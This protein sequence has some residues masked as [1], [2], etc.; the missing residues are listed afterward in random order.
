LF[1]FSV[2]GGAS[3]IVGAPKSD[4]APDAGQAFVFSGENLDSVI[5]LQDPNPEEGALFG[6]D[7]SGGA[8]VI[9]GAPFSDLAPDAGQAFVFSG[10]NFENVTTLNAPDSEE[11]ALFGYSVSGAGDV[12]GDGI[13]DVIVGAPF[14][15]VITNPEIIVDAGKVYIFLGP[16]FEIVITLIAPEPQEGAHFGLSVSEGVG[17]VIA[18]A[19]NTDIDAFTDAGQALFFLSGDLPPGFPAGPTTI[20]V[21]LDIKPQSCPNPINPTKKGILPVAIL[22]TA[23]F[24]V[25][26]INP[27][28]ILLENIP[29]LR[30]DFEDLSTPLDGECKDCTEEGP[31][32]F[33]D[34]TLKFD[35][36]EIITILG[37]VENGNELCLLLTGNLLDGTPIEGQDGIVIRSKGKGGPQS[38]EES[39]TIPT[40]FALHQN[41][42]NPFTSTTSIRYALPK[43]S[44]VS[45]KIY[46]ITGRAVRT[47]VDGNQKAQYYTIKWDGKDNMGEKVATGIYFTRF[48]AGN[49]ASTHKTVLLR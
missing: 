26:E 15:D 5:I 3:V 10:E 23:S 25:N 43:D 40:R 36:R 6:F 8:S 42:P 35:I 18:G 34:L 30:D 45:L 22:G 24:D 41:H 49:F 21:A 2:S 13:P 46:D 11:G 48:I 32:G 31:D 4:L 27:L 17:G 47:L 39:L 19:P 38:G 9:V 29:P 37:E 33:L 7:V 1:G 12:N 20:E 44:K 14:A 16:D 28:S